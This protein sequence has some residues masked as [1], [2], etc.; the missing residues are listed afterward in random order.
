VA[1]VITG[2]FWGKIMNMKLTL[3][4]SALTAATLSPAMAAV[5][6]TSGAPTSFTVDY[7]G[8][9]ATTP[10]AGLTASMLVN[11]LGTSNG[12]LTYDFSYMMSNTS[13]GAITA[14]RV[15]GF[16]FDTSPNIT[17]ALVTGVYNNSILNGSLPNGVGNVEVCFNAANNCNGGGNGG[18]ML[19]NSAGGNF[20]LTLGSVPAMGELTFDQFYVRYQS[21]AGTNLGTS[22]T[23]VQVNAVPEPATWG[24]M[25]F[26]FGLVGSTLRRR[27]TFAIA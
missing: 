22:G 12:G 10:V 5:T 13:G 17:S 15:S 19:G 21:I 1:F 20:S 6:V 4:A 2:L 7:D 8:N 27:R 16:A 9:V 11:F 26:G 24:M 14:S 25:L 18:V 3:L 23:G